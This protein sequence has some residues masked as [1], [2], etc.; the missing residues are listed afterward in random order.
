[1]NKTLYR[2][3]DKKKIGDLPRVLF[4]GRIIMI[5]T[6]GE[7]E[8]AVD[9]LLRSDILGFDTETRPC[10]TKGRQN[11]VALLQVANRDT[12]FLFRLNR[13]GLTPAIKRL[14]ETEDVIKVGLSWHDDT[15][16]LKK[17]G[18]FTPRGFYELQNHVKEIGVE[19]MSLAKIY[20]NLF[21]QR[22][23]KRDQLSNWEADVLTEK[24]KNYAAT[25]AW[26]CVRIY[27][28]IERLKA[29]GE[30]YVVDGVEKV[31]GV[32]EVEKVEKVVKK[33]I[34]EK[35]ISEKR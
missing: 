24:Q 35:R 18:E 16:S 3:Y 10:F 22:I 11:K 21:G 17:R 19:D 4:E 28:E 12:C 6:A 1:M 29:T 27:E 23:S 32:E 14:L 2:N 5:L 9:Y 20:A 7:A 25:D 8:R 15:L 13:F 30:Y 33:K 34:Y 31:D 26:A